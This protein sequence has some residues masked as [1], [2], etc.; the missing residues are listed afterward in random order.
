MALVT[1][2]GRESGC[3]WQQASPLVQP[4]RHALIWAQ[5]QLGML[6]DH[7]T[8]LNPSLSDPL[9]IAASSRIRAGLV[10]CGS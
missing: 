3:S 6:H 9:W 2:S 8:N 4:F 7:G 10:A 1:A 5:R